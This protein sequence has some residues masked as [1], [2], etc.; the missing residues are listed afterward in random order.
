MTGPLI[1]VVMPLYNGRPYVAAA[2]DSVLAQ[3]YQRW[4][5]IVIDDGSSDGG[6]DLVLDA[7]RDPRIRFLANPTNRGVAFTRQVGIS[8][9][10]GEYL[11]WLD[12]DD[13]ILP[14]RLE[15]QLAFLRDHP[16]IGLCG[17]WIERFGGDDHST[18]RP[19][20]D[21]EMLRS[22]LLFTPIVPN[23][24]VMLR[25]EW[26][27]KYGI[28]Y[29]VGLPIAEDYDFVL[30]CSRCFKVGIVPRVLYRYR[31]THNSL[32]QQYAAEEERSFA[33]VSVVQQRALSAFGL[34]A[35]QSGL[36]S[37]RALNSAILFT[38]FNRYSAAFDWLLGLVLHNDETGH[39]DR[40]VFRRAAA[41]RFYFTSK[42]ASRFGFRTLNF[43]A[44]KAL[45]HGLLYRKPVPLCK[46]CV[47]CLIRYD[48]F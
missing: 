31:V 45:A 11:A 37:H 32:M 25:L 22:L 35:S 41:E 19:P 4:E 42:K 1:S 30:Q 3:T 15:A 26:V 20:G 28:A 48:K 5:L 17:T 7:Y 13:L 2:I 47:R 12:C 40:E 34:H 23:A 43:Y 44:H 36:R 27:R 21:P 38:D 33:A 16:D 9:A 39:Y 24:T 8:E 10:R 6:P 29:D 14:E 18:A 46:F